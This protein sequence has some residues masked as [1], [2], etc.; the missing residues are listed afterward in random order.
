MPW[1]KNFGFWWLR[2]V[3]ALQ[4]NIKALATEGR[5]DN[6]AFLQGSKAEINFMPVML[7]RLTMTG[8]TLRPQTVERKGEIAAQLKEKVWPLI[9]GGEIRPVIH[10]TFALAEAA[11]AHRLM[12]SSRHIGKIVLVP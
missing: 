10:E 1:G 4:R 7:K 8:S 3:V 2:A 9:A 5:L 6:I 11:A 12:E